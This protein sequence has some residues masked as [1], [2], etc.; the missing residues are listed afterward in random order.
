MQ[1]T[2][3]TLTVRPEDTE[4]AASLLED[5]GIDAV[6]IQDPRDVDWIIENKETLAWDFLDESLREDKD[7]PPR[8]IFY[9]TAE[10]MDKL[11]PI[12]EALVGQGIIVLKDLRDIANYV[13]VEEISD[14]A[15]QDNYRDTFRTTILTDRFVIVPSWEEEDFDPADYGDR[16]PIFMDPGMAFGTGEHETTALCAKLMEEYGCEGKAVLDVGTGSGI[17]AIQAVRLGAREVLGIDIDPAAVAVAQENFAKNGVGDLARAVEGD[18]VEGIDFTADLAVGNL[19]AGL[20]I[21]LSEH[22]GNHLADGGIFIGSGILV[23]QRAQ[24]E[25]ALQDAGFTLLGGEERGEWCAVAARKG[26]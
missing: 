13:Q 10:E 25:Q 16:E 8:V 2:K 24:V 3:V 26:N 18:L 23:T 17:L 21:R 1:Y 14:E 7:A 15:W 4:A 9:L 22:V 12:L 6:E 11:P 5:A 19:V 20:V